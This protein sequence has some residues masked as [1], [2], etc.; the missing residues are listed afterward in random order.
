MCLG[1]LVSLASCTNS[2]YDV[3][4]SLPIHFL[5][6]CRLLLQVVADAKRDGKYDATGIIKPGC[7]SIELRCASQPITVQYSTVQYST[8][9]ISTIVQYLT[10]QYGTLPYSIVWS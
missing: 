3:A 6:H 2:H 5:L 8:T 1:G 9:P 4:T 10:R 7:E